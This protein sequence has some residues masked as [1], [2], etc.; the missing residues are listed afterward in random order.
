MFETRPRWKGWKG[1]QPP[2]SENTSPTFVILFC[3][4][5]K[6]AENI[7]KL[8]HECRNVETT[9]LSWNNTKGS[10]G[11]SK[12]FSVCGKSESEWSAKV[13]DV[14]LQPSCCFNQGVTFLNLNCQL[15][16]QLKFFAR[17]LL[18]CYNNCTFSVF[19]TI[20]PNYLSLP[21]WWLFHCCH[22]LKLDN[23]KTGYRPKLSLWLV[24]MSELFQM[25]AKMIPD[26]WMAALVWMPELAKT[27]PDG[28]Q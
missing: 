1:A 11:P 5:S 12:D 20:P 23:A 19:P 15:R 2:D 17:F 10:T 6:K 26:G 24:L 14:Q 3:G 16:F 8:S 18:T 21:C 25:N 4:V 27:I 22:L 13:W 7:W 28:R 9:L